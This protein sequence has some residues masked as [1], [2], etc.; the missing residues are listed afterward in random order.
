MPD[1]VI[2]F[3][4]NVAR[5]G[6]PGFEPV[7]KFGH[8]AGVAASLEEVWDGSAVYQ[9]LADDTFS[10]MYI[11][12][13]AEAD[14]GITYVVKGIDSDYKYSV[15]TGTT[16]GSDGRTFVALTSGAADNKWWRIFRA[17][18]SSGTIAAGDIYFSKN[19]T[20]SGGNGIPDTLTDTQAKILIGREK[21]LMSLYT[22]P[23]NKKA[24]LLSFYASTSSAKVTEV[25]V[26]VRPFGGVFNIEFVLSLQQDHAKHPFDI[27]VPVSAKSDIKIMA[28]AAQGGGDVSA[29]FDLLLED[30]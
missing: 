26:Y 20:D 30:V 27:P 21:T 25:H 8:N 17:Y 28:K 1:A 15:V 23:L 4:L 5:G 29:G 12:S 2:P 22:V 14:Q 7:I 10:T 18:N 9:Y 16:D 19:N 6:E 24:Q 3:L 13:S 11:S